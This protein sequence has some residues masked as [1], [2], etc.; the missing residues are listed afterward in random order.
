MLL[1]SVKNLK[2]KRKKV[3]IRVN[4][5]VPLKNGQIEDTTR[6]EESLPTIEF[7][8]KQNPQEIILISHLGRPEGKVVSELSL[9]PVA[10]WL[11]ANLKLKIENLN[12]KLKN[13]PGFRI[14]EKIILL[15][16]LRFFPE[17]ESNDEGFAKKIAELADFYV[18]EAFACSHR[19]HASIVG[20]PK[21]FSLKKRAFGFDFL[22]EIEILKRVRENPQRP[23]VLILGGIKKDKLEGAKKL[24][25]WADWVLI[26]GKL[27]EYEETSFLLDHH[28]VVGSLI[29]S[30]QDITMETA[31]K[32]SEIIKKAKTVVWAGPMGNFYDKRYEKGTKMVAEAVVKS[33]AF[34]V[35]GGG[36]TEAALTK[37]GWEKKINFVSSGGGAMLEF[38]AEGTLPGIKA[39]ID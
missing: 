29:R 15:E 27:V 8:L 39:I 30:G 18:N 4:Y 37:F 31:K 19:K 23:V 22:K 14:N 21:F 12:I 16:N 3:L 6:I 36:D 13:F 35:V 5:D 34:L 38:L 28:K 17:E 26:G 11:I 32:F 1:P 2:V 33:G 10:R 24:I 7:L 9:A 25:S 20:V